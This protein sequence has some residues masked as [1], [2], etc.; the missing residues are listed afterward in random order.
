MV[1]HPF[2]PFVKEDSKTLI[3]GSFPSV[4]SR[5]TGFYYGHPQNR[6]WRVLAGVF[7]KETP[8]GVEQ[9]KTLLSEC[10]VALWD[11]A[12]VCDIK[13]SADSTMKNVRP[14]D[15][16]G[17]LAKYPD[18]R[19]FVNGRTAQK[20]YEKL[21]LP[22]GAPNAVFLPSTSAANAAWS[23]EALTEAWKVIL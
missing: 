10:G 13:G 3:L 9:K 22:N 8:N 14:N 2:E 15:I 12:A 7:E 5:E 20:L 21:I 4:K 11:V 23:M 1:T 18:L 6:F 16:T 17:L 19:V